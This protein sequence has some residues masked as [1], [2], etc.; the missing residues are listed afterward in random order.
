M[1]LACLDPHLGLQ[2]RPVGLQ[3]VQNLL[4]IGQSIVLRLA[5]PDPARA[6][7]SREIGDLRRAPFLEVSAQCALDRADMDPVDAAMLVARRI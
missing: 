5:R 6:G 7:Q 1:A 2:P 3:P 4:Q